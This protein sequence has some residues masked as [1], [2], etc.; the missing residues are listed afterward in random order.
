M[1][2]FTYGPVDRVGVIRK[3]RVGD[4]LVKDA[5][6]GA[7]QVDLT[8]ALR[9]HKSAKFHGGTKHALPKPTWPLIDRLAQLTVFDLHTGAD[10]YYLFPPTPRA[11]PTRRARSPRVPSALSLIH[12]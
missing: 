4:T 5:A 1:T 9:G 8:K 2:I 7:W 12:I 10:K 11:A 6:T 3:L